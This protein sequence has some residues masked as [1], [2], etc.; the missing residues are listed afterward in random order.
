LKQV[1]EKG[2]FDFIFIDADKPT[3]PQY[4]TW[5]VDNLRPGGMVTAHNAFGGGR[6]AEPD[7]DYAR[8][9]RQFNQMLADDPRLSSTILSIGDGMA[10]GIKRS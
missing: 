1:E 9:M 7:S 4:L 8:E 6:V 10:A 5:A 2:P 3:Y